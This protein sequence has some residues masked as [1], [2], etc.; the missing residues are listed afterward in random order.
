MALAMPGG[1]GHDVALLGHMAKVLTGY[2]RDAETAKLAM[3]V[4]GCGEQARQ[5][6]LGTSLPG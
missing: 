6:L 1:P 5:Q 2:G 3:L 4:E